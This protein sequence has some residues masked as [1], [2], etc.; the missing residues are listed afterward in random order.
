MRNR[1]RILLS[2]AL[3]TKDKEGARKH[4]FIVGKAIEEAVMRRFLPRN[5]LIETGLD[6]KMQVRCL[7]FNFKDEK[8]QWLR[9]EVLAR[10]RLPSRVAVT[11]SNELATDDIKK[12]R[13][14]RQRKH[15]ARHLTIES[16]STG[17]E[18]G[19]PRCMYM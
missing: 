10:D 7:V 4:H 14:E 12:H 8:N 16:V 15:N 5:G 6:Y 3:A 11:T 9:D 13:I 19:S 1:A 18:N 2:K 17:S